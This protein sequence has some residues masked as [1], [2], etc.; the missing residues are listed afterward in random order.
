MR[1]LLAPA[2]GLALATTVVL[3][4]APKQVQVFAGVLDG[5]GAPAS[6]LDPTDV[7]VMEDGIDATVT[8][9]ER[10]DWPLKLQLLVDNGVGLGGGGGMLSLKEGVRALLATLPEN[11]EVTIVGTAPQPRFLT[12]ATRDRSAMAQGVELLSNDRGAGRF[13]ESLLEA[14]QRIERDTPD[15]FSV[16]VSVATTSG[17]R[18]MREANVQ[19]IMARLA[20]RPTTVHV[21]LYIGGPQ[22]VSQAGQVQGAAYAGTN[23]AR[24][25]K[26]VTEYTEGAYESI[27]NAARLESLL[28]EIGRTVATVVGRYR[29]Q[30]RITADRPAGASGPVGKVNV[31]L[32]EPFKTAGLS[33]DGPVH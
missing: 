23:Q 3:G 22:S 28:P 21:V 30:Y 5:S 2:L 9:V 19:S 4:Q 24:V 20:A 11:T 32:K 8:R 6:S 26:L 17:D 1:F 33:F 29:Q 18:D 31:G 16:V 7:H 25:A 13:V 12:R 10:L 14:T 27:N 15:A